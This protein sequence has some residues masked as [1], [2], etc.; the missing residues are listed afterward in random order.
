M[1]KKI[2]IGFALDGYPIYGDRDHKSKQAGSK[3]SDQCNGI[4]IAKPDFPKRIY[5]FVLLPTFNAQSTFAD[6]HGDV[7]ARLKETLGVK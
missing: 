4:N 6:F 7:E 1:N 5:Q 2:V 3:N